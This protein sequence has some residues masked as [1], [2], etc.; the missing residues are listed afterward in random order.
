V[1]AKPAEA[2][3]APSTGSGQ[4]L[5]KAE[6]PAA[7]PVAQ[8][9]TSPAAKPSEA[10]PALS[11]AEGQATSPAAKPA[12]K[13]EEAFYAG[14]TIR[15]VVGA[16][17]GGGYDVW[18]RL[19]AKHMPRHLPGAPSMVVENMAGA[20]SMLAA[21][22]VYNTAPKD[23]TVIGSFFPGLIGNQLLGVQ[24]IEYDMAKYGWVG[25]ISE[26]TVVCTTTERSGFRTLQDILPPAR[27]KINMGT[28]GK[29]SVSYDYPVLFNALM[30]TNM[31]IVSGYP[32]HNEVRAAM[33]K[34][35]VDGYCLVYGAAKPQHRPWQDGGFK[36]HYIAQ[37]GLKNSE[38]S[39]LKGVPNA[40]EMLQS[41]DDRAVFKL[42]IGQSEAFYPYATPPGT[43]AERVALLRDAWSKTL[44]DPEMKADADKAR[45]VILKK[46][47][48]ELEKFVN[49]L[50]ASPEN[51]KKRFKELLG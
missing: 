40:Y 7:S 19:F 44:A 8:P 43:P 16:S 10:K 34:G 2:K 12:A 3:P 38:E 25:T 5:S 24:G 11:K 49:D 27:P 47:G 50:L 42:L 46:D 41:E 28:A 33:E 48:A 37:I 51:I 39:E 15:L 45:L 21:N 22:H 35:E 29:G 31:N 32:G 13:P 18:A 23:G 26:P 30:N 9:A 17:P 1:P 14:K 36:F 4:A 6:G 20:A